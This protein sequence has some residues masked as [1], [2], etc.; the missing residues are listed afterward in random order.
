[1]GERVILVFL[2]PGSGSYLFMWLIFEVNI[3]ILLLVNKCNKLGF[4]QM[5]VIWCLDINEMEIGY[6]LD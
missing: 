2:I 1:M 3:F 4:Y 6:K 5:I